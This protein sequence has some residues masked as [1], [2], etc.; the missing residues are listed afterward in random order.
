M[1]NN[2]VHRAVL[3]ADV[4]SKEKPEILPYYRKPFGGFLIPYTVKLLLPSGDRL[5]GRKIEVRKSRPWRGLMSICSII[6]HSMIT[7]LSTGL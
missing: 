2:I 1:E 7:V 6:N 4:S 5:C 3:L